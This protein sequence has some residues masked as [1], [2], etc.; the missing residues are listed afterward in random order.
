MGTV[1]TGAGTVSG[2]HVYAD[3]GQYNLQV[4]ITDP[5]GEVRNL[6]VNVVNVAP[7]AVD[8]Q[9]TIDEDSGAVSLDVLANDSDPA[10]GQDVLT[11]TSVDT[12]GTQ[13]LVGFTGSQ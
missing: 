11:I 13:G 10:G 9:D 7:T 5:V 4:N 6:T 12:N 1:N 8:D 2:S 3:D